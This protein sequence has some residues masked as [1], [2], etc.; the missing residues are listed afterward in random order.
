MVSS[1]E[2]N[3][4]SRDVTHDGLAPPSMKHRDGIAHIVANLL[5][6]VGADARH[7][8]LL[9]GGAFSAGVVGDP[10]RLM[11]P[12][13][14]PIQRLIWALDALFPWF[15][16]QETSWPG[17]DA[18]PRGLTVIGPAEFHTLSRRVD[19]VCFAGAGSAVCCAQFSAG[20]DR[21]SGEPHYLIPMVGPC[22]LSVSQLESA[23]AVGAETWQQPPRALTIEPVRLGDACAPQ[24]IAAAVLVVLR[25][26]MQ[27]AATTAADQAALAD[28]IDRYESGLRRAAM[29]LSLA[30]RC[31][32]TGLS[33]ASLRG[34]QDH[35]KRLRAVSGVVAGLAGAYGAAFD[36]FRLGAGERLAEALCAAG[37]HH[38]RLAA[39]LP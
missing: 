13:A 17:A 25:Q 34:L 30:D 32:L 29:W 24:D 38:R 14:T 12:V 33:L 23:V 6:E 5:S 7:A 39:L 27:H 35:E 11:T 36:A 2:M 31:A 28:D 21:Q 16:W 4:S 22:V 8:V 1:S 20:G 9:A 26:H 37:A 19:D 3:A 15:S 10:R 18:I